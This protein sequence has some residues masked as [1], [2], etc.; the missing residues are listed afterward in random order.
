MR[1]AKTTIVM[2]LVVGLLAGGYGCKK[3]E[4]SSESQAKTKAPVA[5]TT[6]KAQTT[7]PIDDK[8]IDKDI[9]GDYEGKRVYFCC[10]DCRDV[11]ND[12]PNSYVQEME[13]DGLV[14]E[15]VPK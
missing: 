13:D 10:S 3:C 15:K 8:Q 9:Y 2:L 6:A 12:D 11:F 4:E 14:L 7:C 1:T 5:A